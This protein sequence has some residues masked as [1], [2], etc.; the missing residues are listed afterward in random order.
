MR[1]FSSP[2]DHLGRNSP[3]EID[4]SRAGGSLIYDTSG[5]KCIESD[6]STPRTRVRLEH[7]AYQGYG[8]SSLKACDHSFRRNPGMH[9]R[10]HSGS[11]AR[12]A[13][14]VPMSAVSHPN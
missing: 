6:S 11:M 1:S 10:M 13:S 14:T 8:L 3:P 12:A 4:V 2:S 9:Q 7:T 5:R